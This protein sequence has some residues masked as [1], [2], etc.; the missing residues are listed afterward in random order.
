MLQIVRYPVN[1]SRI[2]MVE[3]FLILK[4]NKKICQVDKVSFINETAI[5]A[6]INRDFGIQRS[7]FLL[8]F[9]KVIGL[10]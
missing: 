2:L 9:L 3:I 10:V 4:P 1:I 8:A 7:G 5:F 6:I